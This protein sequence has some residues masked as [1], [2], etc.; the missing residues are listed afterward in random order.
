MRPHVLG[1]TLCR[2]PRHRCSSQPRYETRVHPAPRRSVL[3]VRGACGRGQAESGPVVWPWPHVASRSGSH[4]RHRCGLRPEPKPDGDDGDGAV[5][6]VGAFV[7]PRRHGPEA[8]ERR[9]ARPCRREP[10]RPRGPLIVDD[11]G[12]LKKG[13]R[14]AGMQRQYSGTA[15]RTENCQVGVFLACA[16]GGGWTL[17]DRRCICPPPGRTTERG[18][19]RPVSTTR[20]AS[21]PRSSCP[22]RHREVGPARAL[23]ARCRATERPA[24]RDLAAPARLRRPPGRGGRGWVRRRVGRRR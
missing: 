12:F 11:T 7:E 16:A 17:I 15:G 5:E 22:G 3:C 1:A 19:A 4:G 8:L 13:T 21:R 9:C 23:R 18:A 10:R 2:T 20:S 24:D 6:D 14:S